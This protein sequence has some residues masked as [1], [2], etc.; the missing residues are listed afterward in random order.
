MMYVINEI[1]D[2]RKINELVEF[3]NSLIIITAPEEKVWFYSLNFC[4]LE[5]KNLL[6]V[7]HIGNDQFGSLEFSELRNV[8][9]LF[10][11]YGIKSLYLATMRVSEKNLYYEMPCTFEA[12]IELHKRVE[13][14]RYE[15][16]ILLTAS[17]FSFAFILEWDMDIII[18]NYNFIEE[19]FQCPIKNK[20]D[21]FKKQFQPSI[22]D[23]P[24][25]LVECLSSLKDKINI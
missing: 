13:D 20:L 4:F 12:F 24:Q 1:L 23:N 6:A 21:A 25:L 5:K 17:D 14:F 3:Q 7:P 16:N 18:G 9:K 19:Y 11:K 22:D 15:G 10:N 8:I 2:E